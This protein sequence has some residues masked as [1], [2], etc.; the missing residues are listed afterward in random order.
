[1]KY[2]ALVYD[3]VDDYLARRP[4]YRDDHLRAAREASDRGELLLAGALGDPPDQALLIFRTADASAAEAFA[5]ND[6]YV[7]AGLVRKWTVRP[8][9]VAVGAWPEDSGKPTT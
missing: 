3:V 9:A 5:T 8:W 4:A 7:R 1:M 6:P 2:F